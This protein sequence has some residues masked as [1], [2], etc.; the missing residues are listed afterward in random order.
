MSYE[1]GGGGATSMKMYLLMMKQMI[2][3]F[4]QFQLVHRLF[5]LFGN[6]TCLRQFTW[7]QNELKFFIDSLPLSEISILT[8]LL[9]STTATIWVRIVI[10]F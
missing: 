5:R 6:N 3:L 7:L 10:Y 8:I 1:G 2:A 9:F 4:E